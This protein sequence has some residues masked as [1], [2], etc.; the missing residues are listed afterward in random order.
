MNAPAT[1]PLYPCRFPV[2][3][4]GVNSE[5]FAAEVLSVFR[6]RGEEFDE[7]T[8][9]Q[10]L[11]RGGKYLSLT[12]ELIARSREHVEALYTELNARPSVLIVL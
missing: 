7:G 10:T 11:S 3:V 1:P 2:K 4:I 9:R 6:T 8:V 12:V 5:D